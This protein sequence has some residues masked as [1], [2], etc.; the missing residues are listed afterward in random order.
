MPS[1]NAKALKTI[2][3]FTVAIAAV[4]LA[5]PAPVVTQDA[6]QVTLT[7]AG[8]QDDVIGTLTDFKDDKFFIQS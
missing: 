1:F 3:N 5:A 7:F 6:F 4:T 8:G 2:R